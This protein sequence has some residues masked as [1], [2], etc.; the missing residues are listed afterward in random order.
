MVGSGHALSN[1]SPS[2]A[3]YGISVACIVISQALAYFT[4]PEG[5][6]PGQLAICALAS[7]GMQWLMFLPSALFGTGSFFDVTGTATY[8]TLA[9]Y[10]LISQG[11]Y[12]LRQ[13]IVTLFVLVWSVR[14][15]AFLF[16]RV[17]RVGK[18]QR[19]DEIK[20]NMPRFFNMWT[21]Q[22]LW[23]FL[24]ALPVFC[25]NAI[26][27][28]SDFPQWTD[29]VGILLAAVGFSFEVI[30]DNQKTAF[31]MDP[32]NQDKFIST[33]LWSFSRHPNYFGEICFW[34][35]IFLACSTMFS[36]F[37]WLCLESPLFV[38]FLLIKVSGIPLL[39]ARAE[40]RWKDD[41]A[42]KTYVDTTPVLIPSITKYSV[43]EIIAMLSEHREAP[44]VR[45]GGD[46]L[47][48]H[49]IEEGALQPVVEAESTDSSMPQELPPSPMGRQRSAG[50]DVG[51]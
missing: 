19:F 44:P 13:V 35:G 32:A 34:I 8:F 3:F 12:H 20:N 50:E 42:Y 41:P 31:R 18:D 14:L 17:K 16:Q 25:L 33:G 43:G 23:V 47:S 29:Y 28:D 10:S 26:A 48:E 22:G 39:E 38:A 24:T 30:A 40:R 15:G 7:I 27:Q 4:S 11:T 21:I 6:W 37:Q 5:Q 45:I 46:D 1:N 51:L 49:L 2:I 9:L 36:G